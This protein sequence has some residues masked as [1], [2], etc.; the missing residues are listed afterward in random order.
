MYNFHC[1]ICQAGVKLFSQLYGHF[2]TKHCEFVKKN[3]LSCPIDIGID[4][5]NS[6][7]KKCPSWF[8]SDNELHFHIQEKHENIRDQLIL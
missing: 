6:R 8:H 4:F 3:W 2:V 1:I 7:G 5:K